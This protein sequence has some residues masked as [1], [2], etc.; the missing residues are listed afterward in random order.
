MQLWL[1]HKPALPGVA[2]FHVALDALQHFVVA[3]FHPWLADEK[4]RGHLTRETL[5]D[6]VGVE[7]LG[8]V[9]DKIDIFLQ[10]KKMEGLGMLQKLFRHLCALE[11]LQLVEL[12]CGEGQF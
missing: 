11:D 7:A 5:D 8:E 1:M 9:D 3:Q 10:V 6:D 2:F 12:D 4:S